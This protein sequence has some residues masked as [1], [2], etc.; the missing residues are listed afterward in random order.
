MLG[1][2]L[3]RDELERAIVG[4]SYV[5]ASKRFWLPSHCTRTQLSQV[6]VQCIIAASAVDDE[7]NLAGLTVVANSV[8]R[9]DELTRSVGQWHALVLSTL[10]PRPPNTGDK[11][12]SGARGFEPAHA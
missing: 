4:V 12:R 9:L 8:A 2:A 6:P 3:P 10:L 7:L 5:D 11:L 1:L